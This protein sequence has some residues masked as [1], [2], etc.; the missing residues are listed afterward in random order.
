MEVPAARPGRVLDG[1]REAVAARRPHGRLQA[2][3]IVWVF[4]VTQAAWLAAIAY[5]A[6]R[7]LS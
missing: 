6:Y 7:L 5:G 4:V 3:A 1:Q 2:A